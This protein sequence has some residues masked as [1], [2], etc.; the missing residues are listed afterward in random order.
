MGWFV[1]FDPL[2]PS[3]SQIF[4]PAWL[5]S[6]PSSTALSLCEVGF[7]ITRVF[8]YMI[9]LSLLDGRRILPSNAIRAG[10]VYRKM[11][12]YKWVLALCQDSCI[13]SIRAYGG[14]SSVG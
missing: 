9:G 12:F 13:V 11:Q 8:P 2:R 4:L 14:Y 1:Q 5:L 7:A 6:Q 3:E 10:T